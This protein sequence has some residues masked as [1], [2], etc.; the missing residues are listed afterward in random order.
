LKLFIITL[1]EMRD[2]ILLFSI[3]VEVERKDWLSMG[4]NIVGCPLVNALLEVFSIHPAV[5][6]FQGVGTE[7]HGKRL[8]THLVRNL[9]GM[10]I[11]A[12]RK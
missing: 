8:K 3:A 4:I 12:E 6:L 10:D 11:E 7:R 2:Y 9:S 5:L 1:N